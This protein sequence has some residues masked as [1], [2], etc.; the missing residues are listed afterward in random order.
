MKL[1]TGSRETKASMKTGRQISSGGV[2]FRRVNSRTEVALIAVKEGKVWCLPKGLVEEGEN[3][4]GT[5]HREVN[6][7]TGLDG[8]IIKLID[9][10]QYFYAHKEAEETKR[11]FKIVYFFLMEYTQGDVKNHDSEVNDCRWFPIDDAIKMVE[12]K[13]EKEILKKARRMIAV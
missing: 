1:K 6:E 2:V 3:I 12:Y 13:G 10:I 11:F 7:E 9:H 8:K 4:A 5:A